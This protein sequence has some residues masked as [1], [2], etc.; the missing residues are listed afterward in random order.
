[1]STPKPKVII[2]YC[3]DYDVERI[4]T[5][6]R[7]GLEELDLRP[8]GRTLVKP[9]VVIA[10][11]MF[12]NAFTRPEFTDGVL[13][14]LKDRDDGQMTELAVGERCG[15]TMPTRFALRNAKYGPVIKKH[16]VK[17]YHFDEV[18]QVEI[19][20]AYATMSTRQNRWRAPTSL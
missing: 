14:A 10:D 6:I 16:K 12:Q 5:I 18:R 4:R 20:P 2:R 9:N 7:E 1:V 19:R 3:P 13:G 11:E 17:R 15:I 8:H